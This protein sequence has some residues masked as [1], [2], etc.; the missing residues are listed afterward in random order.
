MATSRSEPTLN[1]R[2]RDLRDLVIA[3]LVAVIVEVLCVWRLWLLEGQSVGAA[4]GSMLNVILYPGGTFGEWVASHVPLRLGTNAA[5]M[6][7]EIAGLSFQ[8]AIFAVFAFG[9][10]SLARLMAPRHA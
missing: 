3:L 2:R 10:I 5:I 8:V 4:G 9:L 6:L 7:G 1:L